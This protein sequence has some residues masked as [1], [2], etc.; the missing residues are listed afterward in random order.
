MSNDSDSP[1]AADEDPGD[2][3]FDRMEPIWALTRAEAIRRFPA[4]TVVLHPD[5][6]G[7]GLVEHVDD[8]GDLHITWPRTGTGICALEYCNDLRVVSFV[9]RH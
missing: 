7:V 6:P 1:G 9:A 5:W 4:G 2:E 8:T 3:W